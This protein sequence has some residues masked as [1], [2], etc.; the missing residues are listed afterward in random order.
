MLYVIG[1]SYSVELILKGIYEKTVGRF[2]EWIAG[3]YFTNPDRIIR[4]KHKAYADFVHV[5]PWYE[6][7][8]FS[9]L[10]DFWSRTEVR[11]DS[12][13]RPWERRLFFSFEYLIKAGYGWL[14]RKGTQAGYEPEAGAVFA[15]G[16]DDGATFDRVQKG[17]VIQVLD[18]EDKQVLLEMKRDAD[19]REAVKQIASQSTLPRFLEISGNRMILLTVLHERGASNPIPVWRISGTSDL[20]TLPGKERILV[21]VPVSELVQ[22]VALALDSGMSIEHIFDY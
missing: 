12:F 11:E 8:F 1:T 13:V 16:V 18:R 20:P 17:G 10:R 5:Y 4:E 22:T 9:H 6:F 14:I 2:T 19:F 3:T 7:N 15:V 21:T